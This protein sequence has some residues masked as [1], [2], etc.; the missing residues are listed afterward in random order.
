MKRPAHRRISLLVSLVLIVLGLG[1]LNP[2]PAAAA[3]AAGDVVFTGPGGGISL[4]HASD[5]SVTPVPGTEPSDQNPDVSPDGSRIAFTGAGPNCSPCLFV[6][7][8]DGSGRTQITKRLADDPPFIDTNPRWS[9]DGQWLV[10]IRTLAGNPT[11]Y[12]VAKIH[13]DGSGFA[14]VVSDSVTKELATWSPDGRIAYT[15]SESGRSQIYIANADGGSDHRI[16]PTLGAAADLWPAWSPD[17]SRIYVSSSSESTGSGAGLAYYTYTGSGAPFSGSSATKAGLTTETDNGWDQIPRLSSDGSTIYFASTGYGAGAS[18]RLFSVSSSGTGLTPLTTE[19]YSYGSNLS[20]VPAA[21]P[22]PQHGAVTSVSWKVTPTTQLWN[23][24]VTVSLAGISCPAILVINVNGWEKRPVI[25]SDGG[26]V[27]GTYTFRWKV[28]SSTNSLPPGLNVPVM[29]YIDHSDAPHYGGASTTL[30]VPVAPVW[31][32]VGDSFSSGHHQ[33]QDNITC[34]PVQ[35]PVVGTCRPASLTENDPDFS[36]VTR[37]TRMLNQD[38]PVEW[39]YRVLLVAASGTTTTQMLTSGQFD[40]AAK[41]VAAKGSTWSIV[42]LTGGAN[43]G[44]FGAALQGFYLKN[45]PGELI[46]P[47]NAQK[48][49]SCPDSESVYRRIISQTPTIQSDIGKMLAKVRSSSPT[50]RF[51]D[52]LYPYVLKSTNVCSLDHQIYD[53]GTSAYKTWHGGGSVI[54]K[55]ALVHKSTLVGSDVVRV[56]LRAVFG[57]DPLSNTQLTRYFGYPHPSSSGQNL[58]ASSAVKALS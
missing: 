55:L 58:I 36:W 49:L 3:L 9:T 44:D 56:D 15:R 19:I 14:P 54:D 35:L 4:R 34:T 18:S 31:V 51:I 45:F 21:W 46:A 23:M 1:A 22:P 2:A 11:T 41:A 53:P 17:G 38:V 42:S 13:P 52:V 12:Q 39:G 50:V 8:S 16:T 57:A 25:C 24:D 30:K 47:W 40:S 28:F 48:L 32:G 20:V 43:N 26:S 10:F 33:D 5:G 6:A 27:A 37:A 29:A 7:N